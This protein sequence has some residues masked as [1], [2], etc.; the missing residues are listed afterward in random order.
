MVTRRLYRKLKRFIN[1]NKVYII[2]ALLSIIAVLAFNYAYIVYFYF[3][4]NV[5]PENLQKP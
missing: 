4:T 5:V 2:F 1:L 3:F